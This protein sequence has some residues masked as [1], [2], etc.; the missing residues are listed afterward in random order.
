MIVNLSFGIFVV[1]AVQEFRL[2]AA[3]FAPTD[4]T[5]EM[6]Y[7]VEA[8]SAAMEASRQLNERLQS[9]REAAEAQAMSDTLTGL[10]NR[11]SMD[12]ALAQLIRTGASFA[13]MQIDLDFFKAVNDTYGHAAGD[14]VLLQAAEIMREE[15]R[16]VDVVARVGGD[17]FVIL[18]TGI[19]DRDALRAIGERL[20]S[21]LCEP[22]PFEGET[23]RISASIGT[24]LSRDYSVLSEDVLLA[25]ADAALYASKRAGRGRHM[26]YDP[27]MRGATQPPVGQDDPSPWIKT[28]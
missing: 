11:R 5:I 2:T 4:L 9:A 25:D 16:S 28:A 10:S 21:R 13:L 18:L 23:C 6:L 24:V 3:D 22:M 20:I 27:E 17:E 7:L 15:T 19:E 12:R 1:D 8:K 26:F 14:H